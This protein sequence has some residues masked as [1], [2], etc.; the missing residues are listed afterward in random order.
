MQGIVT[1]TN[2][3]YEPLTRDNA[4]LVLIDMQVGPL[5]TIRTIEQQELKQNSIALATIAQ[6]YGLPAIFAAGSQSG[7]GGA[8]M[9]ELL[10][11]LPEHKHVIHSTTNVWQTSAF[12]AAISQIQRKNLVMAGIATDI[13]LLFAVLSARSAGYK[14]YVVTDVC[15]TLTQR[16]EQAAF[17][18]M[19]QSGAI[20]SSWASLAA[21]IQRDFTAEHGRRLLE[22]I[23]KQ[24]A[25]DV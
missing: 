7:P 2:A 22:I 23:N 14:V 19:M 18:R 24:L 21:E 25:K 3:V 10:Q 1:E 6:M 13:G 5:S 12:P 15:G 17:M 9:P 8:Y 20:M 16:S 4:V 11:L